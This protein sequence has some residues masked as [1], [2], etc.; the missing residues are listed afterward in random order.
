M[1]EHRG[2]E[3]GSGKAGGEKSGG[4]RMGGLRLIGGETLVGRAYGQGREQ[5]RGRG[6]ERGAWARS[7]FYVCDS[8]LWTG[9]CWRGRPAQR[10]CGSMKGDPQ[11]AAGKAEAL[12]KQLIAAMGSE[13]AERQEKGTASNGVFTN[14]RGADGAGRL[15]GARVCWRPIDVFLL[16]L[17]LPQRI[18]CLARCHF[19]RCQL[20]TTQ[21]LSA[22]PAAGLES[23]GKVNRRPERP[24]PD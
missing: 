7:L 2:K 14:R 8:K 17:G 9:R 11:F 4:R 19:R 15:S 22:L 13:A 12:A 1:R 6:A 23:Q 10:R 20:T 18:I 3:E 16:L 5:E 21:G 24:R